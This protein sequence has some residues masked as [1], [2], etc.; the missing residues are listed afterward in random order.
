METESDVDPV[1][2]EA[3]I[4][5]EEEEEVPEI[6]VPETEE[7]DWAPHEDSAPSAEDY[8]S[9][10][11]EEQDG[12]ESSNTVRLVISDL[13]HTIMLFLYKE[14]KLKG[15]VFAGLASHLGQTKSNITLS[16][17]LACGSPVACL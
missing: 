13:V 14:I 10:S 11:E 6:E 12:I 16:C 15:A 17:F 8:S 1:E 9:Q 4:E 2:E 3:A 5:A 7:T